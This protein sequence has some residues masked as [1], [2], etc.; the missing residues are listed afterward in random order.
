MSVQIKSSSSF[1]TQDQFVEV[2][3]TELGGVMLLFSEI[4]K[5][6]EAYVVKRYFSKQ[7]ALALSNMLKDIA[8]KSK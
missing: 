4:D 1:Q 8:D 7:E 3:T 5:G 6:G 2:S